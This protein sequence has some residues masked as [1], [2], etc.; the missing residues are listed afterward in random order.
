[1]QRY[2]VLL[3]GRLNIVKMSIFPQID[4]QFQHVHACVHPKL[5][6]LCLT[7][8]DPMDYGS[9][10]SYVLGDSPGIYWNGLPCPTSGDLP[11][12]GIKPRSPA[13]QADSLLAETPAKP[14][15]L[16]GI[17]LT[18]FFFNMVTYCPPE[19]TN[20]NLKDSCLNYNMQ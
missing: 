9:P 1:M 6:Q 8:S 13:L 18:F 5:L 10:G 4:E 19:R 14:Q 3:V 2:I 16:V 12:P 15:L 17:P 20:K 7:P 11:N